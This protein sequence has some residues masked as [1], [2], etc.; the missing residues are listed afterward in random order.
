[1]R[2][3]TKLREEV[4]NRILTFRS[5]ENIISKAKFIRL[6]HDSTEVEQEKVLLLALDGNREAVMKWMREH[7]SL[8]LGD[9]TLTQ[10]REVAKRLGVK[11]YAQLMHGELVAE[12]MKKE[13]GV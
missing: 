1:M 12:I 4:H 11:Y 8:D 7:P 2:G 5:V 3:L 10:L 6:W 9:K 13:L